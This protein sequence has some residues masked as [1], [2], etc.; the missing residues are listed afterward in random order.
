M[1]QANLMVQA[2]RSKSIGGGI[3]QRGVALGG[4][5]GSLRPPPV[6]VGGVAKTMRVKQRP[7]PVVE[8]RETK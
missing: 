3:K 1:A 6:P 2:E 4:A 5:S 8:K 7:L